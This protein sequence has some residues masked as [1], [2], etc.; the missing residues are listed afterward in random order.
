MARAS[1]KEAEK[2]RDEIV[3]AAAELFREKGLGGVSVPDL[4]GAAGLTHGGFYGHFSSKD[5]LAAIA[6][7]KAFDDIDRHVEAIAAQHPDN[8]EAARAAVISDYLSP[9]HRD[10]AGQGCATAALIDFARDTKSESVRS[11]Y[12]AGIEGMLSGIERVQPGEPDRATALATLSAL[13]GAILISRATRG[14]PL[15]DE[16]LAAVR[17]NLIGPV[18]EG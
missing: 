15:S 6:F 4:M 8:R 16:V 5:A 13:V 1:R 12:V 7:E 17:A 14:A 11:A 18:A 10:H 9:S 2:H 3:A